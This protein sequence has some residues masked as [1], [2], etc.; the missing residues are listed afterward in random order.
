MS[1]QEK[2][3]R[4]KADK[5]KNE[6]I[7]KERRKKKASLRIEQTVMTPGGLKWKSTSKD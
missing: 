3:E 2:Y 6:A 4:Y 5:A 7:I 1:P